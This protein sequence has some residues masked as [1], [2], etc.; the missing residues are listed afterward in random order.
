MED[1]ETARMRKYGESKTTRIMMATVPQVISGLGLR[2]FQADGFLLT[3]VYKRT[4]ER[5][6][7]VSPEHEVSRFLFGVEYILTSDNAVTRKMPTPLK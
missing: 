6:A 4:E 3:R 5:V 2:K 1:R 7:I